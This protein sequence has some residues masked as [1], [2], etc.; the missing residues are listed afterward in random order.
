MAVPENNR[1]STV[2][3]RLGFVH[4]AKFKFFEIA[5]NCFPMMQGINTLFDEQPNAIKSGR[6]EYVVIGGIVADLIHLGR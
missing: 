2:L 6:L 4:V 1:E 5:I 3:D